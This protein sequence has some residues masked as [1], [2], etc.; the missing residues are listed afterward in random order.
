MKNV[1][2]K[3]NLN[4]EQIKRL[5]ALNTK[6]DFLGLLSIF[7]DVFW[8]VFAVFLAVGIS[9]WFYPLT[10]L[11]IGARQRALASLLHEAAHTTLFRTRMLNSSIGRVVC[12]W[13]ILQ[14]YGVY[15]NSHVL[16]HHPKIGDS[17]LDPDLSY[18]IEQGVYDCG[19]KSEF[20]KNFFIKP[21]LGGKTLSYIHYLFKDRFVSALKDKEYRLEMACILIFHSSIFA[22]SY[23]FN[24]WIELIA[25]WW[26]PFLIIHPIIGWF[27]ELSEH[28]PMMDL[29][30][31]NPRFYSRNRYAGFVERFFI[32]MHSDNLHLTHHLYPAVPHWHLKQATEI[33][34]EDKDFCKWDSYWGGIF[35]SNHSDRVSLIKYI[36]E[37]K[38]D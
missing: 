28:Y 14:S 31:G 9:W 29:N 36:L 24:F 23:F 4:Q 12:G 30:D 10:I 1:F 38:R 5:Q 11:I 15:R 27:S 2:L 35:T 8:I 37:I 17:E 19:S 7:V 34:R 18:M 22:I 33:L 16:N 13:T 20:L 25:F 32:G 6:N 3:P 21:L 26:I